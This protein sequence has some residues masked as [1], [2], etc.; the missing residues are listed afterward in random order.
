M[1]KVLLYSTLSALLLISCENF[2]NYDLDGMWQL[3]TIEDPSGSINHTDTVFRNIDSVFYGFQREC[4]FSYT[5][6]P[7][8]AFNPFYGYIINTSDNKIHIQ[9][10]KRRYDNYYND[11]DKEELDYINDFK[12]FLD[13]SG[14]S[15]ADIIFEIKKYDKSNL[16]LFDP[17]NGKI[18]TFKKF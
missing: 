10:D 2:R 4:V 6:I 3:K 9:M 17:G 16:I 13:L 18:F 5:L 11:P 1:K 14:W 12:R 7:K 8:F 15:S